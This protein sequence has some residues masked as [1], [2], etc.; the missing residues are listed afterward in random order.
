MLYDFL[1]L[2]D[3]DRSGEISAQDLDEAADIIRI[4]KKAKSNNS[5]EL[6]YKHMPP[7]VAEVLS[8]WDADKSGSVGVS[9]LIMAAEAMKKLLIGAVIAIIVLM[10]GTFALALSAAELAKDA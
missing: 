10:A 3:M 9:E 8:T 2:M 6:N 7:A 4:A 5:A 1:L